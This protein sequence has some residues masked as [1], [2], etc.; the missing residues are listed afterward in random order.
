MNRRGQ[1]PDRADVLRRLG[2][3][4]AVSLA[5][6]GAAAAAAPADAVQGQWQRLM[7]LHVPAAWTAYLCF[8]VV[9]VTNAAYLRTRAP[10]WGRCA[11]AAAEVGVVAVAV[12][13]LTGSIWGEAVWGT[14]WAWDPRLVSTAVLGA[15]YLAYL[16]L[17]D[18]EAVWA[19]TTAAWL[20]VLS[21]A[22]VPV[23][24][25]SVVW[26]RTLHQ[27]A[28]ILAPPTQA[29]PIDPRMAL[30]LALAVVAS[31]TTAL[32]AL[33]C[34][35]GR[36]AAA[37]RVTSEG[38]AVSVPTVAGFLPRRRAV[39]PDQRAVGGAARG[40]LTEAGRGRG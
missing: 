16:G 40:S 32:W 3:L 33:A 12:T 28:T 26:W 1:L 22:L 8:L 29:P 14:W 36:L 27:P 25:F 18:L 24:H 10:Q 19:R 34:R 6:A 17:C 37:S 7:Y 20:G 9:L 4:T 30:A 11:Q 38:S 13:L 15:L 35:V 31:T 39:P 2:A 5:G 21:F 23:V